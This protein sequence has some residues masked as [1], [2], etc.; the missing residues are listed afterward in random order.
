MRSGRTV[1]VLMGCEDMEG[2]PAG[3]WVVKLR[4]GME[5]GLTGLACEIVASLLAGALGLS[6]PEPA[7]VELSQELADLMCD[8]APFH[9]KRVGSS[10]GLNFG[11]RHLIDA[12]NW[13][14]GKQVPEPMFRSAAK[15][16]AFD[17]LS[18]NDD[19]RH[20]NTNLLVRGDEIFVFDHELAFS[21]LYSVG[22][23]GQP[24][25][26]ANRQSMVRH[27][28]YFDLKRKEIDLEDFMMR[29]AG[30]GEAE[31][32]RIVHAVPEEWRGEHLSKIS[33]HIQAVR[34]HVGEFETEIRRRLT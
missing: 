32:S 31:M 13:P 16:F 20:D 33:A 9:A 29:L 30:L 8:V 18:E 5:T 4:G 21:F 19:R 14:V 1:P 22:G 26:V 28:F 34:E 3:E 15:V 2:R 6:R 23:R 25:M 24:W 12:S 7:V 17:A 27:V 10:V 11:T